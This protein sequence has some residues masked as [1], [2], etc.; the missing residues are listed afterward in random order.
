MTSRS[1]SDDVCGVCGA[2]SQHTHLLGIDRLGA[3][4]LDGRPNEGA[5][6]S[7]ARWIH[8]CPECGYCEE[9]IAVAPENAAEVVDSDAYRRQLHDPSVP[10]LASAFLCAAMIASAPPTRLERAAG[11]YLRA[12]WACDDAGCGAGASACRLQAAET[13]YTLEGLGSGYTQFRPYGDAAILVDLFRRSGH[14]DSATGEILHNPPVADLPF[15]AGLT[16][17]QQRL[18][19]AGDLTA[20]SCS[21][22]EVCDRETGATLGS[23][24]DSEL[25]CFLEDGFAVRHRV[26]TGPTPTDDPGYWLL[27]PLS[28]E[29]HDVLNDPGST[30]EERE[31]VWSEHMAQEAFDVTTGQIRMVG[32]LM[33]HRRDQQINAAQLARE[34]RRPPRAEEEG[35]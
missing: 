31:R 22:V 3:P 24:A 6:S 23:A 18:I 20:H 32:D 1:L 7:L 25:L 33:G 16:A 10:H 13:L 4:D 14:F 12:A 28:R 5:G 34:I 11:L 9:S 2:L 19:A 30:A 17:L 35:E 21:E 26:Q 8:R 29:A 15:F 27:P